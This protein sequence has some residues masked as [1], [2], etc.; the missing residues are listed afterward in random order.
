MVVKTVWVDGGSALGRRA[1]LISRRSSPYQAGEL[2]IS[3]P[4]YLSQLL[5]K[6]PLFYPRRSAPP[7]LQRV[8][9]PYLF[10]VGVT[11]LKIFY[12]SWGDSI[13]VSG[14]DFPV[15]FVTSF[16]ITLYSGF[17]RT[18]AYFAAYSLYFPEPPHD[19]SEYVPSPTKHMWA[20]RR[21]FALVSEPNAR[22]TSRQ[23][24]CVTAGLGT[25]LDLRRRA[26]YLGYLGGVDMC[27]S[28]YFGG[29]ETRFRAHQRD[30]SGGF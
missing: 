13:Y 3:S 29:S 4:A 19:L 1:D 23:S 10:D 15:E 2:V 24:K 22:G 28:E 8:A 18:L 26:E 11:H 5:S 30:I 25:Y 20:N 9:M 14:W 21:P 17:S 27:E 6:K 7:L 12:A 16:F